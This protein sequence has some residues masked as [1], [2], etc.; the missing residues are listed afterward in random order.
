MMKLSR[1]PTR[2]CLITAACMLGLSVVAAQ[3]QETTGNKPDSSIQQSDSSRPQ[4][5]G[6]R[7]MDSSASTVTADSSAQNSST[8]GDSSARH[9]GKAQKAGHQKGAVSQDSTK[10]GYKVDSSSKNQNP[11]GYRGMERP[12]NVLPADSGSGAKADT[13][14][15]A[16]ATSRINQRARQ[17]SSSVTGQNPPGYRGMERPAGLDT[18][19]A[20]ARGDSMSQSNS[21]DTTR[22]DTGQ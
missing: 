15:P 1:A 7:P 13:T 19:Q 4:I 6:Y 17:D 11:P 9:A 14:A 12:A 3:A 2:Q 21:G 16:D 8:L 10:W 22:A 5:Q 18:A 20:G